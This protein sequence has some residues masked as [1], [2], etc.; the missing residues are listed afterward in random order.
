MAFFFNQCLNIE[1]LETLCGRGFQ[2]FG[3]P[4]LPLFVSLVNSL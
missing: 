4:Y 2:P 1:Y 3:N